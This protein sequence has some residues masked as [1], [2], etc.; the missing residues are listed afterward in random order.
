MLNALPQ[1]A[2]GT[3]H[4]ATKLSAGKTRLDTF[5]QEG[6][7]K[8]RMPESFDGSM[9][10]V[11]IN[12]SGG[13]TGGDRLNWQINAAAGTSLTVTTQA[14]ERI[15][16]S[17]GDVAGVANRL[18]VGKGA[19]LHWLPQETILFD[20]SALDRSLEID[21]ADGAELVALEAVLLGRKAMGE[22]FREG[23][24]RDRWRVRQSGKLFH[25][26]NLVFEGPVGEIAATSASLAS[27]SA[28]ATLLYIGPLA[29]SLIDPLRALIGERLA[30]A[31]QWDGKLV[32]R[33]VAT[34]GFELR[35][36]LIPVISLLRNGLAP[37]KVWSL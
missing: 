8:F 25:A 4:L 15:Y 9:E 35:K 20:Q 26:E 18:T 11:M 10:A 32:V 1:R 5:Y 29:E 21:L 36:L 16:R 24:F 13:L 22:S 2:K 14:C 3:A 28:F 7:A 19:R 23:T 37:P 17:S 27:S 12:T 31:S 6:C 30:G 34:D 33:M